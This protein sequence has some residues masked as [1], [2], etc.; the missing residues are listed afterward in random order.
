M[1]AIIRLQNHDGLAC[2]PVGNDSASEHRACRFFSGAP[3]RTDKPEM[4]LRPATKNEECIAMRQSRSQAFSR[5]VP[6]R[7]KYFE[8][9]GGSLPIRMLRPSQLRSL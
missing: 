1:G 9:H 7:Q 5:P 2:S 6:I 3:L 8:E 4:F